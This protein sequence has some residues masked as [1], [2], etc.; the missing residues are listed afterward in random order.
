[1]LHVSAAIVVLM[2]S[3]PVQDTRCCAIPARQAWTAS[4]SNLHSLTRAHNI[5]AATTGVN[6]LLPQVQLSPADLN[7]Q[8]N[9]HHSLYRAHVISYNM[10]D[11][12]IQTV[13]PQ[14]LLLSGACCQCCR[15]HIHSIHFFR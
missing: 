3:F 12:P 6:C 9:N 2:A 5:L 7:P 8:S 15:R 11:S 10:L 4:Q 13:Q 14:L 1:M